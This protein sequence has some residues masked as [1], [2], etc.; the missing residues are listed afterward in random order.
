VSVCEC[1]CVCV[2]GQN[3]KCS[4]CGGVRMF[5]N[6]DLDDSA[7]KAGGHLENSRPST[8]SSHSCSIKNHLKD[9]IL[10]NYSLVGCMH[11]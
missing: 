4:T 3:I 2:L 1:V 11:I 8:Q 9:F 10:W 5:E 6:A 7:G